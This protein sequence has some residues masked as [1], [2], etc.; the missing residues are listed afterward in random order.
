[1]AHW[2]ELNNVSYLVTIFLS[3]VFVLQCLQPLHKVLRFYENLL[4]LTDFS[5]TG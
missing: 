3:N 5:K 4:T 2:L 1:M